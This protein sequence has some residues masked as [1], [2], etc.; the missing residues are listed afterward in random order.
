[1]TRDAQY[2]YVDLRKQNCY[3]VK[4]STELLMEPDVNR[5]TNRPTIRLAEDKKNKVDD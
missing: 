2:Y 3:R 1:M 4:D 5:I